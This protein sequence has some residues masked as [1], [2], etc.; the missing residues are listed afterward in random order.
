[1]SQPTPVLTVRPTFASK[2]ILVRLLLKALPSAPFFIIMGFAQYKAMLPV[3]EAVVSVVILVLGTLGLGVWYWVLQQNYAN[4][5]YHFYENEVE[6]HDGFF[7]NKTRKVMSYKK[8]TEAEA[9]QGVLQQ[10]FNLGTIKL[11]TNASEG[12]SKRTAGIQLVD[13]A[14]ADAV[15]QQIKP[16]VMA[17]A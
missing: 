13:I 8:V 15:Y 17:S 1:M 3:F 9:N 7:F 2:L 6:Y 16:L 14:D 11:N 12:S 5:I 4:T 10:S